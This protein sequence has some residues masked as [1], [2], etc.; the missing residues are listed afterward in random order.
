MSDIKEVKIV[1]FGL[2]GQGKSTNGCFVLK[3]SD[4][5]KVGNSAKGETNFCTL[6]ENVIPIGDKKYKVSILDTFGIR[7]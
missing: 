1:Y 5:F 6:G 3:K 7:S 4:A 2:T